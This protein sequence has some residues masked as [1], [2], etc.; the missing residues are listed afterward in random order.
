M[1]TDVFNLAILPIDKIFPHEMF[2]ESRSAN[3]A[4]EI[5]KDGMIR[6]PIIVTPLKKDIFV[7]LDGMNRLSTF[8]VLGFKS[9]LCQIVDYQDME[10]VELSSW[11]HFINVRTS[12]FLKYFEKIKHFI[13]NKGVIDDVRN[14]YVQSEGFDKICTLVTGDFEVYLLTYGGA[15]LYKIK[16]LNGIVD[17]YIKDIVR[18]VLPHSARKEDIR[19]LF[20]EHL[21][22]KQ[23]VS[24]PAFT[25]HQILK[26]VR[27]KGFFP[28]G[29]TRHVIRR[30]CLNVNL[31]LSLLKNKASIA[32][33]NR[34]LEEILRARKFRL[35]EE[36][37]IYFE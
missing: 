34:Q 5:E 4:K 24:F 23:M 27:K 7:Q 2:D 33:Q 36:P 30:R 13:I 15:L 10:N 3:L 8:K 25:R 26:V 16:V 32:I 19:M 11:L 12:D 29:I 21:K 14:R 18:S 20:R 1:K 35:Y 9:I 31:P 17:Y 37:T 6:N 22:H 28:P